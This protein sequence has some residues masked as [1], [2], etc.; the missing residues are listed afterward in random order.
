V[1]NEGTPLT[2]RVN[3]MRCGEAFTLAEAVAEEPPS[4]AG[5]AAY[6]DNL[7]IALDVD[8]PA[9]TRSAYEDMVAQVSPPARTVSPPVVPSN[10]SVPVVA[11]PIY[12]APTVHQTII[13]GQT[14]NMKNAG[15][16]AVLS[17]FWPG[18][19]QFYNGQFL[20]GIVFLVLWA[21][22][23]PVCIIYGLLGL[24]MAL[25]SGIARP[26]EEP[27]GVGGLV[28]GVLLVIFSIAMWIWPITDAYRSAERI[29]RRTRQRM[30]RHAG[31]ARYI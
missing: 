26:G 31:N 1:V 27:M 11:T 8:E 22:I 30:T 7:A 4:E 28:V 20:K 10:P 5:P 13:I 15:L 14:Q 25:T 16:A 24:L 18:L 17:F 21:V 19:G 23:A 6:L 9:T 3:C 29:N 12:D 2:A